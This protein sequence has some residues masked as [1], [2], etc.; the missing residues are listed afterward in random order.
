[1]KLK[2]AVIDNGVNGGLL[3]ILLPHKKAAVDC[4]QVLDGTCVPQFLEPEGELESHGTLCTAL[5]LEFLEKNHAA[6]CR[7]F[8]VSI[9]NR[10]RGQELSEFCAALKWCVVKKMD[11]VLMSIGV[12][13][14]AYAKRLLPF[15]NRAK[16]QGTILLA[17]ASNAFEITYPACYE[18]AIGVKKGDV[19]GIKAIRD[20]KD[21]IDLEGNYETSCVMERYSEW[22]GEEYG[23][24]N[25]FALPY[26]AAFICSMLQRNGKMGKTEILECFLENGG[27]AS[28]V[29]FCFANRQAGHTVEG[30]IPS[31]MSY[32]EEPIPK[33]TVV[34]QESIE[35]KLKSALEDIVL[36]F[37]EKGYSCICAADWEKKNSF[38]K[39]IFPLSLS[40]VQEDL[41][42]YSLYFRNNGLIIFF[43]EEHSAD[44][45]FMKGMDQIIALD[46]KKDRNLA[47][48]IVR[49]IL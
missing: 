10:N 17:A 9:L 16:D 8:S 48:W 3:E 23:V 30:K 25:S 14:P 26:I 11:V 45:E 41:H 18:G 2:I 12:K 4:R 28:E 34:Y 46:D 36:G 38:E 40:K 7:I 42:Y 33:I 43:M 6:D 47:E 31:P 24:S 19:Y 29:P 32:I 27:F 21:G 37:E 5:L 1:M 39:N 49:K 20:P 44:P 35:E 22:L 15:L 13:I